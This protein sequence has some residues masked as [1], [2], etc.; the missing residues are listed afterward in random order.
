MM[1]L[2]LYHSKGTLP[3]IFPREAMLLV[4]LGGEAGMR[5]SDTIK[6][7]WVNVLLCALLPPPSEKVSCCNPFNTLRLLMSILQKSNGCIS[8]EPRDKR[9]LEQAFTFLSLAHSYT[10]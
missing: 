10:S 9:K 7:K 1:T 5:C 2:K 4:S 8:K 6:Q 3:E